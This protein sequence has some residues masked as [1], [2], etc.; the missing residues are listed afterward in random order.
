MASTRIT[1][2]HQ[3][4]ISKDLRCACWNIRSWAG[5]EH[6]ILLEMQKHK[7]DICAISET[8]R[9]GKGELTYTD[10]ILKYSGIAKSKRAVAGV[11]ILINTKLIPNIEDTY[12]VD[13]RIIKV[14]LDIGK[15][16]IHFLSVYAPDSS[17]KKEETDNFYENLQKEID[18]IPTGEKTFILGDMNARVG[19]NVVDGVK[20]RFSEDQT[21]E[22]GIKLTLFC[23]NNELRINNTY[24]NHKKQHKITWSNTRG[25]T[26]TIDY[27]ITNRAIH[28]NIILDV[29]SLSQLG[30]RKNKIVYKIKKEKTINASRKTKH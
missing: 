20:Q 29:R 10:Y 17:R 14:V 24:F 16:K 19:N 18:K 30:S 11:G 22:N 9:K 13:E 5:R 1:I 8:K 21:N 12:Y 28:P 6:E 4:R 3:K 7:I 25:S 23:A 26:S 2:K 15:E 27:I